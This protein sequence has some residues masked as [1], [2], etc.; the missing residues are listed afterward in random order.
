[1]RRPKSLPL[2]HACLPA[3]CEVR[4]GYHRPLQRLQALNTELIEQQSYA[5]TSAVT[6]V[7]WLDTHACV[8][9]MLNFRRTRTSCSSSW[10]S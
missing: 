10:L 6:T 5:M 4:K 2:S 7:H 9:D 1:M 3:Q 8:H